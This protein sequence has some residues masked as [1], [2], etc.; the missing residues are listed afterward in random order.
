PPR[1]TLL[2]I[3]SLSNDPTPTLKGAAGTEAGDLPSVKVTIYEGSTA[4]GHEAASAVVPVSAGK[5]TYTAPQLKD[6]TYTALVTQSDTS[7]NVGVSGSATF[8]I[9]TA[10]PT[11]TLSPPAPVSNNTTPSFRG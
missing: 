9:D 3:P 10:P 2:P 7:G 8:A 11:V 6:G 1:V 4:S 5:W